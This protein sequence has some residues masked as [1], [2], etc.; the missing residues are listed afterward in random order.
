MGLFSS[1]FGGTIK[2]VAS[3]ASFLGAYR[4]ASGRS[5]GGGG[6]GLDRWR[7][8]IDSHSSIEGI[9]AEFGLDSEQCPY[10]SVDGYRNPYTQAYQEEYTQACIEVESLKMMFGSISIDP[11]EIM[12]METVEENAYQYAC[13]LANAWY[14]GAYWIPEEVMEWAWYTLSSHNF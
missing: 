5:Y 4:E 13:D 7:S 10:L 14:N 12:S 6:W 9:I 1:I 11:R 3:N 2:S 8:V